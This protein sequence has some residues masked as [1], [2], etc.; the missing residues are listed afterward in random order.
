MKQPVAQ[1]FSRKISTYSKDIHSAVQ[2][3]SSPGHIPICVY[4]VLP[5]CTT[6]NQNDHLKWNQWVDAIRA[7]I[8]GE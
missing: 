1:S 3:Y 2:K 5:A 7:T 6:L 4:S 8:A